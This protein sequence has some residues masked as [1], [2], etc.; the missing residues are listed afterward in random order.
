VT[1]GI[2]SSRVK[3]VRCL[4]VF[5]DF[6]EADVEA[7]ELECERHIYSTYHFQLSVPDAVVVAQQVP[8]VLESGLAKSRILL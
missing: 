8:E 1:D 7:L 6:A 4:E 3:V 5:R 2:A